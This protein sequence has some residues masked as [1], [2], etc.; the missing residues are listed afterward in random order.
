MYYQKQLWLNDVVTISYFKAAVDQTRLVAGIFS[1]SLA[2]LILITDEIFS[3][4][5]PE[6]D[7]EILSL[8]T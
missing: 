8:L 1:K 5:Y 3:S 7:S 4:C 2:Y 6:D